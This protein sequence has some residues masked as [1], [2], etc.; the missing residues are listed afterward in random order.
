M[1]TRLIAA[2][3]VVIALLSREK[4]GDSVREAAEGCTVHLGLLSAAPSRGAG[5]AWLPLNSGPRHFPTQPPRIQTELCNSFT[6]TSYISIK[7]YLHICHES[8]V[9]CQKTALWARIIVPTGTQ[10]TLAPRVKSNRQLK[11]KKSVQVVT[12]RPSAWISGRQD[13]A[14]ASFKADGV[15]S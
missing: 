5:G 10:R 1:K 4:S 11:K 7:S 9:W 13:R 2:C 15:F 3:Y 14:W 12:W 8:D 6:V